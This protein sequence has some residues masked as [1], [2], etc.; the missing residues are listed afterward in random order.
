MPQESKSNA[1]QN[2]FVQSPHGN[3]NF[4][5]IKI[6]SK[7]AE[8]RLPKPPKPPEKPLMPYMRYSRR[9]WEQ[10]KNANPQ[11]KLWEVGKI[12]GQMWRELPDDEKSEYVDEYESE[13]LQYHEAMRQYH[14]SPQYQAWL[15]AKERAEKG[16]D[17]AEVERSRGSSRRSGGDGRANEGLSSAAGGA[18]GEAGRE[19]YIQEETDEEPGLDDH[20]SAKHVAAARFQRNHCLMQELLSDRRMPD[21]RQYISNQRLRTLK[22]Q[23]EQLMNHETKLKADI[24]EMELRLVEK[25]QKIDK[26]REEFD[27]KWRSLCSEKPKITKEEFDQLVARAREALQNPRAE[28]AKT[29]DEEGALPGSGRQQVVPVPM[30]SAFLVKN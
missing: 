22:R 15:A 11:L 21:V 16:L 14:N 17:D 6:G 28:G 27:E 24:D 3:P 26:C 29:E 20:L 2:P 10:V 19:A 23:V 8:G 7:G 1:V 13:K 9:V 5:P 18:P 30:D 12:I 25:K 4:Q